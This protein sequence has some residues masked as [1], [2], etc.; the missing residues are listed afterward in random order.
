MPRPNLRFPNFR[1]PTASSASSSETPYPR[2]GKGGAHVGTRYQV[3]GR[4]IKRAH[5]VL[6]TFTSGP[7]AQCLCIL[8]P[9]NLGKEPIISSQGRQGMKFPSKKPL[10][11]FP[12]KPYGVLPNYGRSIQIVFSGSNPTLKIGWEGSIG[13]LAISGL[14]FEPTEEPKYRTA[15]NSRFLSKLIIPKMSRLMTKGSRDL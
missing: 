9:V 12:R 2:G 5:P 8:A 14:G 13:G 6:R 11:I 7:T 1:G 3:S 4:I 15:P 10:S